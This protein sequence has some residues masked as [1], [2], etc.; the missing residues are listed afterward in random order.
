MRQ[1]INTLPEMIITCILAVF[2]WA[3][4]LFFYAV[5]CG[6]CAVDRVVRG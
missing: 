3:A 6:A 1:A 5:E 4:F 2:V